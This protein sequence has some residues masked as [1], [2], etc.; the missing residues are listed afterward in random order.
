MNLFEIWIWPILINI[1][2]PIFLFILGS[3]VMRNNFIGKIIARTYQSVTDGLRVNLIDVDSKITEDKESKEKIL[4]KISKNYGSD[5]NKGWKIR[6]FYTLGK[7]QLEGYRAIN[8]K[9]RNYQGDGIKIMSDSIIKKFDLNKVADDAGK[10]RIYIFQELGERQE[11]YIVR[12]G[13]Q[14]LEKP[15][16]LVKDNDTY[17]LATD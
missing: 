2:S 15:I 3:M 14:T 7:D 17:K 5:E 8:F 13:K 10:I 6:T 4:E 16:R 1:L 12:F 11:F 9:I